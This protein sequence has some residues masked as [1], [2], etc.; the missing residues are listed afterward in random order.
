MQ[1]HIS[2]I[3]KTCFFHLRRIASIRRYLTPDACVK[4][5]VSLIFSRL[6][7]C[8]SLLAGLSASSIHG[9]QRVQNYCQA[10]VEEEEARSHHPPTSL[11]ALAPCQHPNLLQT[12]YSGLQLS[13]RLNPPWTCT[14]SPP[15]VP[16][17]LLLTHSAFTYLAR[18][19]QLLVSV[20]TP[21]RASPSGTPCRWSF[22]RAPL[23]TRS[24]GG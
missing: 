24:R 18:N 6:D 17:V 20:H 4:L 14:P 1:T 5:V 9:L 16:F 8:N 13:Q 10:G 7:Y 19:S 23:L 15:T 22:A 3:I 21:P 12:V 11:L 2:F